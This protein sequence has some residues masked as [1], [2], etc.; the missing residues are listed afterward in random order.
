MEACLGRFRSRC[1]QFQRLDEVVVVAVGLLRGA[2]K[3]S[4]DDLDAVDCR[5]DDRHGIGCGSGA[6]ADA[7]HQRFCGV[8]ELPK[9]V[10]PEKPAGA[11]D[12]VNQPENARDHRRVG[13]IALEQDKLRPDR[14]DLLG[15]LGQ[16]IF[17]QLVHARPRRARGAGRTGLCCGGVKEP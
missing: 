15:G 5:Q 13:R 16:K 3:F 14:L 6:V 4:E 2:L 7:P 9:P 10:K 1:L 12:R 11:F 8:R 17:E